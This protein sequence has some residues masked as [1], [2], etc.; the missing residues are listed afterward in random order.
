MSEN[1]L[2]KCVLS[3]AKLYGWRSFHARPAMTAKGY[4]T[5]VQ[6]DGKGFP[7]LVLCKPGRPVLFVELKSD[8]GEV[9]LAQHEWLDELDKSSGADSHVWRPA[10]W[11]SGKILRVL[12]A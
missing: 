6:G 5:P 1:D 3:L 10:Y 2:L 4:R 11:H 12:S 7:D 9:S 8:N